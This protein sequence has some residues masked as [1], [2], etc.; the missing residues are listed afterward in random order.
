L[1]ESFILSEH[2][3]AKPKPVEAGIQQINLGYNSEQDRLV[4]RVGLSDSSGL[5]AW[6]TYR[7]AKILW[8]LLSNE[9]HLPTAHSIGSQTMPKQAVEQF[10]QEMQ[11]VE[12]LQMRR[13]G[14]WDM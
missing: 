13:P 9:A 5:V 6:L 10:K 12:A 14:S 3:I 4:L 11:T 2:N 1:N 8:P 7:V